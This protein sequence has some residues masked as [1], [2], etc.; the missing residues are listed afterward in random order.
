MFSVAFSEVER[1]AS[2]VRPTS[3]ASS[4][5]P[6][7]I[8][9]S[10][11]F[12]FCQNIFGMSG[13]QKACVLAVC[14]CEAEANVP[15]TF[16]WLVK[17][18]I[19][20]TQSFSDRSVLHQLLAHSHT[21]PDH[22]QRAVSLSHLIGLSIGKSTA[23]N[24]SLTEESFITSWHTLCHIMLGILLGSMSLAHVQCSGSAPILVSTEQK[25]S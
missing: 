25:Q 15:V 2:S 20:S 1:R 5:G 18:N 12:M 21:V 7:C 17:R 19:N 22:G 6:Q 16:H 3:T 8:T 14:H 11:N 9:L 23:P 24:P 10:L 13:W 4:C